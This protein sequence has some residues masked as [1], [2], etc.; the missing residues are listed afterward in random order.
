MI[1]NDDTPVE[2]FEVDETPQEKPTR[3]QMLQALTRA[4]KDGMVDSSQA[5][6]M[7]LRL[8]VYGSSFT[9]KRPSKSARRARNARQKASRRANRGTTKGQAIRKGQRFTRNG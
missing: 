4:V 7:R 1:P 6:Q 8:G 9:K 3:K 5:M 2:N